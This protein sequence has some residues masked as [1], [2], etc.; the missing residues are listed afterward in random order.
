VFPATPAMR[1]RYTLGNNLAGVFPATPAMRVR[2]D[3]RE[4]DIYSS[5]GN[6]LWLLCSQPRQRT[7]KDMTSKRELVKGNTLLL[8]CF[9]PRQGELEEDAPR[10]GGQWR[11]T[12]RGQRE[13]VTIHTRELVLDAPRMGG[14]WRKTPRGPRVRHTWEI[15]RSAGEFAI[16]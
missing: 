15:D 3:T 6:I 9:Q 4:I 14:Q 7:K 5:M 11:K 13:F 8:L 1:V 16:H 10:M 2:Y 12:P